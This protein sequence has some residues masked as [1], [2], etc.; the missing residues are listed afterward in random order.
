MHKLFPGKIYEFFFF[1]LHGR[2]GAGP[3]SRAPSSFGGGMLLPHGVC[4]WGGPWWLFATPPPTHSHLLPGLV[5]WG[6]PPGPLVSVYMPGSL[7]FTAP[8]SVCWGKGGGPGDP[9]IY[10]PA[11]PRVAWGGWDGD[12]GG[13]Q[14]AFFSWWRLQGLFSRLGPPFLTLISATGGVWDGIT[15]WG[16]WG[17]E[18]SPPALSPGVSLCQIPAGLLGPLLAGAAV[19]PGLSPDFGDPWGLPPPVS[20]APPSPNSLLRYVSGLGGGGA[21]GGSHAPGPVW[22]SGL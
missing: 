7:Q 8:S 15:F 21:R 3:C 18:V 1:F 2:V 4:V 5:P 11:S 17:G 20:C 16:G 6:G 14:V 9:P 13:S 12:G 19:A 22:G 10:S